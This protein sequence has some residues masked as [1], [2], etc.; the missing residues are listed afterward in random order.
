[1]H[2]AARRLARSTV[3]PAL[4]L[5]QARSAGWEVGTVGLPL[6]ERVGQGEKFA[7]PVVWIDAIRDFQRRRFRLQ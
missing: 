2:A 6:P 3:T 4:F 7:G 5:L 1:M